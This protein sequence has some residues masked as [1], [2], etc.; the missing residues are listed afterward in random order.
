MLLWQWSLFPIFETIFIFSNHF[1]SFPRYQM[2][3]CILD[4]M[5]VGVFSL[6]SS[7]HHRR[8]S[9]N[10]HDSPLKRHTALSIP[11]STMNGTTNGHHAAAA[12]SSNGDSRNS[13]SS[14]PLYLDF[15]GLDRADVMR[16]SQGTAADRAK[17]LVPVDI[18]AKTTTTTM[19]A[20]STATAT[21]GGSSAAATTS[22][23]ATTPDQQQQRRTLTSTDVLT[24]QPMTWTEHIATVLFLTFGVPNGVLTIP[25][26]AVGLGRFVVGANVTTSLVTLGALLVPLALWPQRFVPSRLHSW[27]AIQV[28]KYFSYRMIFEEEPSVMTQVKPSKD[29]DNTAN[30]PEQQ[31]HLNGTASTSNGTNG[32]AK[33][34]PQPQI[35]VAPPHGV[36]PYGNLLAMLAWPVYT[37]HHFRG[38]AANAAVNVPIFKQILRSMGVID[39]SRSSARRAL[40]TYPH[41]IGISTG[42]VAEVFETT[43]DDECILL[44]ERIGLIKLA[45]RTGADIVPCYIFGNTKLLSCWCG[46][47]IPGARTVLE[48]VSRRAGFALVLPYGRY[49]LPIP[50]RTPVFAVTGRP[51]PTAHLQC[52]E[53]TA[54]QIQDVQT[55]LIDAMQSLFDRYKHLYGWQEKRLVIK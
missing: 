40:E 33:H 55:Q 23:G 5:T 54:A 13:Q 35:L 41:A 36:F 39:A 18:G 24:I 25:L 43:A 50:R 52:E 12:A 28:A 1:E 34:A 46:Y 7:T 11:K 15:C 22:H 10:A 26:A 16:L 9:H 38:L 4:P 31:K 32:H 2:N 6:E 27:M 29:S 53:P 51:I 20:V 37:G 47:G 17:V 48:K 21:N 30:G 49:G 3:E 8:P 42:G 14:A 45:I 19:A 44:K